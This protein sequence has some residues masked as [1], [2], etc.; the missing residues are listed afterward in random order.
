MHAPFLPRGLLGDLDQHFLSFFEEVG[1][2]WL[3]GRAY[4]C[5]RLLGCVLSGRAGGHFARPLTPVAAAK[6][7]GRPAAQP[8]F[9]RTR[10]RGLV[11]R[12]FRGIRLPL[13]PDPGHN[14]GRS[15]AAFPVRRRCR[16]RRERTLG[17]RRFGILIRMARFRP[18]LISV[19]RNVV[20]LFGRGS[21]LAVSRVRP[22]RLLGGRPG[23]TRGRGGAPAGRPYRVSTLK[24]ADP[25]TS[26]LSEERSRTSGP[27]ARKAA[28]PNR[29]AAIRI[30]RGVAV[31]RLPLTRLPMWGAGGGSPP[32]P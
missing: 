10:R 6:I 17:Q 22:L 11:R 24:A 19:R 14:L 8:N 12:R 4:R 30:D 20:S 13:R 29:F 23:R 5:G 9:G 28:R 32:R 26:R 31:S 25:R 15:T 21:R 3:L 18:T 16:G 7:A 1:D 27:P 2:S